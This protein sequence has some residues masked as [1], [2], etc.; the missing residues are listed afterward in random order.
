MSAW[1]G[2]LGSKG[3]ISSS[4]TVVA[5]FL[6]DGTRVRLK[7]TKLTKAAAICMAIADKVRQPASPP[8]QAGLE[9]RCGGAPL[10]QRQ[11]SPSASRSDLSRPSVCGGPRDP[12]ARRW[13]CAHPRRRPRQPLDP[14]A[15]GCWPLALCEGHATS[16]VIVVA[17]A[18]WTRGRG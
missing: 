1:L 6:L 4:G 10:G 8:R 3:P 17:A 14:A 12:R 7:V 15:I 16:S 11:G 5:V 18:A 2:K 9:A 13:P